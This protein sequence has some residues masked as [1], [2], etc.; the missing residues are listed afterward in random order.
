MMKHAAG[1]TPY[2]NERIFKH[3]EIESQ[4]IYCEYN[5]FIGIIY[6]III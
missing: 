3:E 5:L 2:V 4:A 6:L 1:N